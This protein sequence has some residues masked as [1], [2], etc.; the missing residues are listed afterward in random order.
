LD[1][2]H[3]NFTISAEKVNVIKIEKADKEKLKQAQDKENQ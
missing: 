1:S 2:F 3:I